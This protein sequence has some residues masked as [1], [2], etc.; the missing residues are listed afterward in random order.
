MTTMD[1]IDSALGRILSYQDTLDYSAWDKFWAS[2]RGESTDKGVLDTSMKY[3]F[4]AETVAVKY[5]SMGSMVIHPVS[6]PGGRLHQL[7]R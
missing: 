2:L 5:A 1:L 6:Q 4:S 7:I 3:D